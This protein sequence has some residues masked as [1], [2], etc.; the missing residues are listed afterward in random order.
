VAYLERAVDLPA[1]H[2][3]GGRLYIDGAF[4]LFRRLNPD[5]VTLVCN[6]AL[7]IQ[8]GCPSGLNDPK[9]YDNVALTRPFVSLARRARDQWWKLRV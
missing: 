1:G 3:D 4:T 9:W 7:S 8:K 6:H 5:V 2:P